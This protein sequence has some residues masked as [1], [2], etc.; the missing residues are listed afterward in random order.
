[1]GICILDDGF[2]EDLMC[3]NLGQRGLRTGLGALPLAEGE[4]VRST[5]LHHKVTR[6]QGHKVTRSQD[7]K[8]TRSQDRSQGHKV[9]HKTSLKAS[10][11]AKKHYIKNQGNEKV[12]GL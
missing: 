5:L 6:S 10:H 2:D 11:K 12:L 1:M 4:G 8:V 9:S 3:E 7:H